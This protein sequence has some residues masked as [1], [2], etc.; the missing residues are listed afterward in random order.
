MRH[1]TKSKLSFFYENHILT[2]VFADGS[3]D[4]NWSICDVL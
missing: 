3:N 2:L 4:N 1:E